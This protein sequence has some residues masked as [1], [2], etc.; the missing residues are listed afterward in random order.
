MRRSYFSHWS[1]S[2]R[3]CPR[4]VVDFWNH[5]DDVTG[6]G[7]H[8]VHRDAVVVEEVLG[9]DFHVWTARV[10]GSCGTFNRRRTAEVIGSTRN[11]VRQLKDR[12]SWRRLTDIE[13]AVISFVWCWTT[14]ERYRRRCRH[15][16]AHKT[17]IC[18]S[19]E[20]ETVKFINE[21]SQWVSEWVRIFITSN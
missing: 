8:Q 20:N 14:T 12:R 13:V 2:S 19:E 6:A 9:W 4:A 11:I 5:R 7:W 17:S 21:N 1:S 18:S 16:A 15:C 3:F 10:C